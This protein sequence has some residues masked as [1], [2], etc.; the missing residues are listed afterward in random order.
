M[1]L[2]TEASADVA[3]Q[4]APAPVATPAAVEPPNDQALLIQAVE[5][6]SEGR[7]NVAEPMFRNYLARH[8]ND[9]VAMRR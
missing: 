1:V 9:P 3:S 7:V 5:H 2:A 4:P 6:Q 8:P